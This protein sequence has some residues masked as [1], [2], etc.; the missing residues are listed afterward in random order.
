MKYIIIESRLNQV[1]FKYLDNMNLITKQRYD[2]IFFVKDKSDKYGV[3]RYDTT[4]GWLFIKRDLVNEVSSFFSLSQEESEIVI[5]RWVEN[6]IDETV[7]EPDTWSGD[8]T[9][10]IP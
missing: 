9:F 8:L 5:S 10:L 7:S 2:D 3:L 1:I 6:T 4:D